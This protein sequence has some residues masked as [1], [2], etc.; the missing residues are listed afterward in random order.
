MDAL[1]IREDLTLSAADLSFT[2][3]RSGGPGGQNVNKVATA[4]ELRFDV[5]ASQ[6]LAE[7]VKARLVRLAGSRMTQEG[8]L[9]V[10]A[11]SERSQ[12]QNL[13]DA[14]ERLAALVRQALVVPKKR[15]PTRPT[16][17]SVERRLDAKKRQG[18]RKRDRQWR[19]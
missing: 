1:P 12:L 5:R 19:D 8:V 10:R 6:D 2:A 7:P 15:R 17:G 4:V 18:A 14:R 13:A 16:K 11:E 9:I 3:V